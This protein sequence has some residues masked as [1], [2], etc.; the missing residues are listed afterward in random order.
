M[1][2]SAALGLALVLHVAP[3][4]AG[5]TAAA[6]ESS[7]LE[8]S[9]ESP[10]PGS[11]VGDP[12]GMAFLSGRAL[13]LYGEYQI[14]DI[15]LVIDTSESTAAPS[16]ADIDGDGK[17][18]QTRGGAWL[19]VLGRMLPLPITD[20]D[21][22]ILAAEIAAAQTLINNLDPRTTRV[23]VIAF[24]G[25]NDPMTPDAYAEVALTTDFEKVRRGLKQLQKRGPN[26]MTNMVSGVT[27]AMVELLGTD[28]A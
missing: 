3:G 12:G 24:S 13:A 16:G 2:R 17:V 23:G 21:D 7:K 20:R 18:G 6:P 15:M 8:L 27:V 22:T 28:S 19:G 25:D 14:F 10:E 26:G 5:P 4:Q 9:I 11:L 1:R